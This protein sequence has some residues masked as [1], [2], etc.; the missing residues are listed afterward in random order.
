MQAWQARLQNTG[1][2]NRV[3]PLRLEA[4]GARGVVQS[5]WSNGWG[6]N[7]IFNARTRTIPTVDLSCEDYGLVYRLTGT[8]PEPGAA[9]HG[10][11]RVHR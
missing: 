11:R 6:V 2:T 9:D 1:Q 7:K 4:A 3:L 10:R 8:E 5:N